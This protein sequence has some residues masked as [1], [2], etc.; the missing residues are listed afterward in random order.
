MT[1]IAPDA[2]KANLADFYKRIDGENMTPLWE[3]LS[4]LV[5]P[6]PRTP[7]EP[8]HWQ[9]NR[10]R[11]YL[12]EAGEL[13]SAKQAE[14]RVLV[15]ENPGLRGKSSATH[16]L[17]AGI[18]LI[19]PGEIAPSHRH[20][21]T[22]VRLIMEGEGGYTAVDGER[23]PMFPGDFII[24][25]SWSFHDHGNEGS[26]P[27]IWLDG[28]DVPM[29]QFFDAA[30]SEQH[31]LEVQPINRPVDYS[32]GN[33]GTG[34]M[35]DDYQVHPARSPLFRYPY[36]QTLA[37]LNRMSQTNA[38]NGAHGFKLRFTHP[39]TGGWPTPTIGAFM[40]MLPAGFRG[41]PHR[42]T[43]S[44]V[45]SVVEGHGSSRIGDT[46][47]EWGPRDVFVVPSWMPVSHQCAERAVLFS[48]S[49]R[50]VQ[51]ALGIWREAFP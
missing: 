3:V 48:M 19:L 9:W 7:C 38:V 39:G 6:E 10:A 42:S 23:T 18:Q 40:Q 32:L 29:I 51:Q 24:T 8:A 22:A 28:L 30:F 21:A 46:T 13:I 33:V 34:M 16:S 45:Y 17:Y 43:D 50:P 12:L 47:I 36:E 41:T 27:V 11:A 26:T 44:K 49:D 20:T 37:L 2:N 1:V 4:G 5:P 14:R 31:P 35:P 15:L 25:L